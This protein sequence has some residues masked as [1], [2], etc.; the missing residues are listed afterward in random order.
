MIVHKPKTPN[1]LLYHHF[2]RARMNTIVL[3]SG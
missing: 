3:F 2:R 1:V